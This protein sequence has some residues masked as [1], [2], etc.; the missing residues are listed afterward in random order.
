MVIDCNDFDE[1]LPGPWEW[2]VGRLAASFEIAGRSR[3][4]GGRARREL[5]TAAVLAYAE[6][7]RELAGLGNLEVRHQREEVQSTFDAY[8]GSVDKASRKQIERNYA[9]ATAKTRMRALSKLT[10]RVDGELR[11]RLA[12]AGAGAHP[13]ARA[14]R[15]AGPRP[16][17][18]RPSPLLLYREPCRTTMPACCAATAMS[19][20]GAR[21]SAS[22][23]SAPVRGSP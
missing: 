20:G 9:K 5:V 16:A 22:A 6:T 13:R 11:I 18:R 1:T 17:A 14:R 8:R 10:E 12:A 15:R 23:A 4:L 3:E 7:M 2:D 21:S 19:T